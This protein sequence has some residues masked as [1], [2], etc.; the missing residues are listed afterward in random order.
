MMIYTTDTTQ[1][2]RPSDRE[3]QAILKSGA[4]DCCKQADNLQ[5]H[6]IAPDRTINV[7]RA[8]GRRHFWFQVEPL[9]MGLTP[10]ATR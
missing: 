6:A 2:D 3:I 5:R 1:I 7:C 9:T 8:C 4:D 10:C